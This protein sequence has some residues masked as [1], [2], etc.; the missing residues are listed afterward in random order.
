MI[1]NTLPFPIGQVGIK[2]I[3]KLPQNFDEYNNLL[4][5]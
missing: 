4:S 5:G 2:L 1:T 3:P